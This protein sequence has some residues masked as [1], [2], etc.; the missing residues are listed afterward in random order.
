MKAQG[1]RSLIASV[2]S[3][4]A[5]GLIVSLGTPSNDFAAVPMASVGQP[6]EAF[7]VST[8]APRLPSLPA[9]PKVL[10]ATEAGQ[11]LTAPEGS[12][13]PEEAPGE[14][15]TVLTVPTVVPTAPIPSVAPAAAKPGTGTLL[16]MPL[17]GRKTSRFGMRF[18][19]IRHVWKLHSGLDLAAPCGTPIGAAAAGTVVKAGWAGG[20]GIQVKV[21]HG[22]MA[23]HRVVTTYNHLSAIGVSVGQKVAVNQ[24][25]GRVGNTGFSTGCHLHFEVIADG[26]F[27]NPE[28]WLNGSGVVVDTAVM[29]AGR[30][31]TPGSSLPLP[32]SPTTAP[33][34]L[35]P[36]ATAL[37]SSSPTPTPSP[38]KSPPAPPVPPAPSVSVTPSASA[39]R[40]PSPWASPAPCATPPVNPDG[41]Q[42]ENPSSC[43]PVTPSQSPTPEGPIDSPS[44]TELATPTA[45]VTTPTI[46]TSAP[47]P[48]TS[49]PVKTTISALP[50]ATKTAPPPV[51]A[52]ATGPTEQ[53][54]TTTEASASTV[55]STPEA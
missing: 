29:G 22:T 55:E 39:T 37:P 49:A 46:E 7:S 54:P 26:D 18:H 24:G 36:S 51:T 50:S 47:A 31:S 27:T 14:D 6:A 41:T 45:P 21:D 33:A 9:D 52:S 30:P 11:G 48:T 23:G 43:A 42:M 5:I 35:P 20:N 2:S 1:V 40:S 19:P 38:S 34:T 4:L 44:P 25:V 13:I 16:S 8:A 32:A 15:T 28:P 17:Q 53:P 3:V 10:F 12:W